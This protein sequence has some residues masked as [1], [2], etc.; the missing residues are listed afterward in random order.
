MIQ[1]ATDQ[2]SDELE[3]RVEG[4][5]LAGNPSKVTTT[6]N[7]LFIYLLGGDTCMALLATEGNRG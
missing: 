6:K 5:I 1:F 2:H 7:N 4:G 3:H